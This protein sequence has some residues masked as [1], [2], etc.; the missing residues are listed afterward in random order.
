MAYTRIACIILFNIKTK[1]N[2]AIDRTTSNISDMEEVETT[3]G[4][5]SSDE[6]IV[7]AE[8]DNNTNIITATATNKE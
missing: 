6:T 8:V 4:V 5:N 1:G 2:I 7:T 3:L